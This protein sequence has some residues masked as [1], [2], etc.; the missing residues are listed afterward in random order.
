MC[1]HD[2]GVFDR[3]S[4]R[5]ALSTRRTLDNV[6]ALILSDERDTLDHK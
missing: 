6:Q 1:G 5:T 3:W 2:Q 4:C